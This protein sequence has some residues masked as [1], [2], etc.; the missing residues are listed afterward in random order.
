MKAPLV[1]FAVVAASPLCAQAPTQETWEAWGRPL[2]ERLRAYLPSPPPGLV[3]SLPWQPTEPAHTSWGECIEGCPRYFVSRAAKRWFE[4]DSAVVAEFVEL[5]RRGDA[6]VA[7]ISRQTPQNELQ[8]LAREAER[9][10]ARSEELKRTLGSLELTIAVNETPS[11]WFGSGVRS[12]GTIRGHPALTNGRRFAV[13]LGPAGFVNPTQSS[14]GPY[15]REVKG[16]L[17][18]VWVSPGGPGITPA[19]E[20]LARQLLERVDYPGLA[21]LLTP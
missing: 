14:A 10:D 19:E 12:A 1:V 13:Y 6:L 3:E 7:R 8:E 4:Y 18:H 15:R 20:R 11:T 21:K 16:I 17:V 5:R 9:L 2:A